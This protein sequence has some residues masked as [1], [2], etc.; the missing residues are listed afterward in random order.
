MG[1]D[2]DDNLISKVLVLDNHADLRRAITHNC[3]EFNLVPVTASR[4]RLMSVLRSNIDLGAVLCSEDYAG[5]MAETVALA[6]QIRDT[7]PE[8]PI[9]VRRPA[10]ADLAGLPEGA[11]DVFCAAYSLSVQGS[12]RDFVDTY[13]FSLEY[14]PALVRGIGQITEDILQGQFPGLSVRM[15]SPY[16]V[17]DRIIAGEVFTL[18]P[19]DSAWCRGY[20]QLQVEQEPVLEWLNA[21]RYDGLTKASFREVN[22]LLGEVTNLIWGGFKNRYIG[23]APSYK[24]STIQVP[25]IVNQPNRYIS[26]GTENPQLCFKYTLIDEQAG[27]S[28]TLHQRFVFNLS[29]SPEDF[30]EIIPEASQ[31]QDSGELELF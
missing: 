6:R 26:F 19:L 25:I 14:P 27:E 12:L 24:G 20:M 5:S 31:V 17:R 16:I 18:I 7:R 15:G 3:A 29:W 11:S 28:I 9:A 30:K 4:S 8:L 1:W 22:S 2:V 13:L 23:D 21:R 10:S